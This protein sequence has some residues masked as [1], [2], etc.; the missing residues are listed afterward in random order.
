LIFHNWRV[1]D[2]RTNQTGIAFR[3][4]WGGR[5]QIAWAAVGNIEVRPAHAFGPWWNVVVFTAT[6]QIPLLGTFGPRGRASRNLEVLR[7]R[8]QQ[9]AG[10]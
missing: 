4:L 6:E 3:S 2:L 8:W 5:R 10:S 7:Q 1:S 9:S